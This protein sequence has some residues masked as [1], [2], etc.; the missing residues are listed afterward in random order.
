MYGTIARLRAKPGAF[1][2]LQAMNE[3]EQP[4]VPGIITQYVYRMDNDPNEYYL[5][6]V[7]E[8]KEAYVANAQS[9]EQNERFQSMVAFL[10]EP[11]EW[12]DGEI[13]FSTP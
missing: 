7:F 2:Q 6:V 4:Q 5:V 10:E 3:G 8:S 1:E 12:H 9:P 11:P 13:V